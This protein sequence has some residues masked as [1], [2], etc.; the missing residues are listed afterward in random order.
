M[1]EWSTRTLEIVRNENYLDRLQHL[2]PNVE[3]GL[4]ILDNQTKEMLRE[5]FD[6]HDCSSLLNTLLDLEKFP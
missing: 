5:S 4:R 2:Y 3:G 6:R 1:N